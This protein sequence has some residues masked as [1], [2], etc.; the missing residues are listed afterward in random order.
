M[1]ELSACAPIW[2][3]W[4][5]PVIVAAWAI[6]FAAVDSRSFPR[7][8]EGNRAI[9]FGL[10]VVRFALFGDDYAISC[11]Q[12]WCIGGKEVGEEPGGCFVEG[13]IVV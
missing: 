13:R 12:L 10:V 3:G 4:V 6:R 8:Q 2:E 5:A 7:Q 9:G 1:A 11:F